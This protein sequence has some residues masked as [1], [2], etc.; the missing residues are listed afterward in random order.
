MKQP[1]PKLLLIIRGGGCRQCLRNINLH[2][3]VL[4]QNISIRPRKPRNLLPPQASPTLHLLEDL[5][6]TLSMKRRILLVLAKWITTIFA[7]TRL[8][9]LPFLGKIPWNNLK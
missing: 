1:N 6:H 8:S 4:P 3:P 5:K 2:P 9:T 7:K